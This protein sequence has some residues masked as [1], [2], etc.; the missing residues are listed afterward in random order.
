MRIILDARKLC[1]KETA[2]PYLK[3]ALSFPDYYGG[4]LDALFDCL[5]EAGPAEI[6]LDHMPEAGGYFSRILRVFLDASRVNPDLTLILDADQE[7][8]TYEPE[9]RSI[10]DF[11]TVIDR[12]GTNS[13]KY[14]TAAEA[15]MP[16]DVIP[17]WVA[18]MDFPAPPEVI[19][20]MQKRLN[21]GIFGYSVPGKGYDRAVC[22]WFVH[23]F[24]WRT[25]PSWIIRTPGVVYG[26]VAAMR[27]FSAEGD[28][29]LIQP[30]VYH[31]FRHMIL[32]N[33]RKLVEN[34]LVLHDGHYSIDFDDMEAKIRDEHVKVFILCSPHNPAGRVWTPEELRRVGELCSRYHVFVISDEIHCDFTVEGH[35]HTPFLKACPELASQA[36]VCTAPSKTFNIAGL[37]VSNLFAP[38]EAVRKAI[39]AESDATGYEGLNLFALVAGE[40]CY[41]HG[42]SWLDALKK[43]LAG[44]REFVRDFLARC[45]PELKSIEMEGTYLAWIDFSG[46]GLSDEELQDLIVNK[47]HLWLDAGS[48]FGGHASQF[49]R[50]VLACPRST[51]EEA[52]TR[53]E[54]AIRER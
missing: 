51:L 37:Q 4:N 11:D 49:Q 19:E 24:G 17:L 28:A 44:N 43:Y 48:I 33:H 23:R 1:E 27:A 52:F 41:T 13:A 8:R 39:Q 35:P 9:E 50:F 45:L 32:A 34:E 3:E 46:L 21:H 16:A 7:A 20:A 40:A 36:V 54:K 53:L 10:Y 6:E 26:V 25:K 47:A 15:G 38:D 2:H 12:H 18:D 30:P 42:G 5:S 31:P 29:V 22:N 14:D